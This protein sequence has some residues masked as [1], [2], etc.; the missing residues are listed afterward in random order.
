[1][2]VRSPFWYLSAITGLSLET[3]TIAMICIESDHVGSLI[4]DLEIAESRK[5]IAS[6]LSPGGRT[7]LAT[8]K[9]P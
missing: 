6:G 1:M 5:L 9:G 8:G 3:A 2:I 7:A 4:F